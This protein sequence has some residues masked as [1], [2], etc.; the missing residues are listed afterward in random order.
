MG[1]PTPATTEADA[2]H[3]LLVLPFRKPNGSDKPSSDNGSI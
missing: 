2:M 3:V 1:W